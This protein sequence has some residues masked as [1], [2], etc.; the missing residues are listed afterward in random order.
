MQTPNFITPEIVTHVKENHQTPVYVYSEKQ[1]R[2]RAR[3]FMNFPSTFGHSVRYAMKANPQKNI[4][5]IFGQEGLLI[6]ASSDFEAMRAISAGIATENIQISSQ[7]L[8]NHMQELVEKWVFFVATSLHQL[9]SFWKLFPGKSCGIRINPWVA[10][11]AF[12]K[13]STGWPTSSF[14]IWHESIDQI[15]KIT[16]QYDIKISKLHF[17]IGSENTPESWVDSAQ[18]GFEILRKIPSIDTFD[19]GG[20]FKMAIMPYE[21]SADLQAIWEAVSQKFQDFYDETG[22]KI[23]LEMEP[24]KYLVINSCSM[25][26]EI[27]DIVNTWKEGYTF[28][29]TNSGMNDM[30]RV[31]MYGVQEPLYIMNN[32]QEHEDYVVVGHCCESS[33][34]ITTKLY[35]AETIEPRKLRKAS[36]GD[37]LVIDGVWAYNSGMAIKNYNSFPESWELLLRVNWEI[38]EIRKRELVEDIWRNEIDLSS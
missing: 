17:H 33:D 27:Q 10:S 34:M 35:D 28:L 22:R 26:V 30:P 24:G 37:I 25:L 9:E 21:S 11:W 20:W 14:G 1:L 15:Q 23:H 4:L 8:W 13:I 32:S 16:E 36:I 12:A 29:K 5:K 19:M 3:E 2:E 31:A 6:D 38:A 7:E 18:L